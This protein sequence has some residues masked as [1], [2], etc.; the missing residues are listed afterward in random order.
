MQK[1]KIVSLALAA[2]AL[3]G[4]CAYPAVSSAIRQNTV[5][6]AEAT[7]SGT[8]TDG[9]QYVVYDNSYCAITGC[10]KF[11]QGAVAIPSAILTQSGLTLPVKEVQS[12]YY[13]GGDIT[14]LTI[15]ASISVIPQ[16]FC[17]NKKNLKTVTFEGSLVSLPGSCFTGC[18]SLETVKL[19]TGLREIG[20]NAFERCT[21]LKKI[22]LPS[23]LTTIGFYAF[24]QCSALE[25][26]T[27][28]G[29]VDMIPQSTFAECTSL[30]SVTIEEGV[31]SIESSAF[32]G[33]TSLTDVTFPK[34]MTDVSG[35][36]IFQGCL[37]LQSVTVLNE[38]CTLGNL[39]GTEEK[40]LI[41]Y[42]YQGSTAE[43][44]CEGDNGS[45]MH[46]EFKPLE[47]KP[48]PAKTL[49]FGDVSGDGIADVTDAQ[50]ILTY[51]VQKNANN[52][53]SWYKITG[54]PNAPD[55]PAAATTTVTTNA[56]TTTTT[57]TTAYAT[58]SSTT[59]T[60]SVSAMTI[61]T[62]AALTTTTTTT[63]VTA[64]TAKP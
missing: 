63:T 19:P 60:T 59:T 14:D 46:V 29:T 39:S 50:M 9:W 1:H 38:T 51:Y 26:V 35:S 24:W 45:Y 54:N 7:E 47:E 15:P 33:C 5:T 21:R 18:T 58:I 6:A 36:Q 42:G 40:P 64:K 4:F 28:P 3:A 22:D 55:A 57:T 43:K 11:V 52:N 25:S 8:T 20:V 16:Q 10:T 37:N 32:A 53:P 2:S 61:T 62:E 31:V 27:I 30:K 48:E 41:I 49:V 56:A 12:I 44:Y 23:S 17:E 34:S 13:S